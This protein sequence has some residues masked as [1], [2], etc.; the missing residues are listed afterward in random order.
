MTELI[1]ALMVGSASNMVANC[2]LDHSEQ[3]IVRHA[4]PLDKSYTY[5][6]NG[7]KVTEM[8]SPKGES[9][10]TIQKGDKKMTYSIKC[11][12]FDKSLVY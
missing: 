7:H 4:V 3:E 8:I 5:L 10:I 11:A 2:K 1:L 9:W 6:R 12:F